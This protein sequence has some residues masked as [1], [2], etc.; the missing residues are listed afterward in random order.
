VLRRHEGHQL[1]VADTL[2]D[3]TIRAVPIRAGEV[4]ALHRL[5][6]WLTSD[7]DSRRFALSLADD[8]QARFGGSTVAPPGPLQIL[9]TTYQT[10]WE[11]ASA[12]QPEGSA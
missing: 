7:G 9:A 3:E 8:L 1:A 10:A 4:K 5:L 2:S 11:Q 12:N 6:D